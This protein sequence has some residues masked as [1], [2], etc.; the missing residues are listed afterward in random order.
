MRRTFRTGVLTVA[1]LL[2]SI[3]ATRAQQPQ[4]PANC[5]PVTALV[6]ALKNGTRQSY[7]NECQAARDGAQ[8]IRTGEC[9]NPR[10][11]N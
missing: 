8:V 9:P 2:L 11:Y 7:W 10:S 3:V 4:P 6:C 1:M 5:A